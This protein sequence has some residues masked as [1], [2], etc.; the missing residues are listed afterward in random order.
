[1]TRPLRVALIASARYPIRE[2]FAGGLEAHTWAL[3]SALRQRGHH[4]TLFAGEGSDP[5]LGIRELPVARAD[6]SPA[7]R[8]DVSMT[9]P[10]FLAEHH[11]YLQLMIELSQGEENCSFDIIH[12]NSLHYL[13]IAMA[14]AVR[15]PIV[16]TLHTPPTPWLESAIQTGGHTAVQYTAVS[17]CTARAWAPVVPDA[18]VVLNGIDTERWQPGPGG[19]DLVW[20][21]RL[22]PEKGPHLAIEAA[23]KAGV[24][25]RL[26]GPTP[27]TEYFETA[28]RPFLDDQIEYVGHLGRSDLSRLVGQAA[29]AIVTPCWDEPYGLVVAEALACGT[30]VCAFDRGALS[31]ILTPDCGRLV[32]QTDA[33]A[34]AD[35]IPQTMA[36]SRR[37]CRDRA[38]QHCSLDVMIT[39]YEE[40]YTA[41][42]PA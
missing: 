22:V 8:S 7:A 28:L 31:E 40:V 3:A 9:A 11:A 35:V 24:R 32:P 25:L 18:R 39:R 23:R 29:A 13:P 1:M 26:A 4:V 19:E 2:P 15:T 30:P 12:N 27:D 5:S 33:A 36:L 41:M 38:E 20:F 6:F 21:G 34:L 16:T 17:A 37:A 42:G 14:P 10:T